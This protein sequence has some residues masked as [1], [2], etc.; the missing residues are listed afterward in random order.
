MLHASL[1]PL[2]NDRVR[3]R[4]LRAEDATAYA[5]GA[6]DPT[7]RRYAHLP[8]PHY[9]PATARAMIEGAARD[10]LE[11]GDLAVL[12]I[13][14]PAD[15][16]F[17]GSLV[18]FDVTEDSAEAGFWL[19]PDA[20]GAGRSAAALDL[21]I[22][23]VRRSGLSGLTAR[24]VTDNTASQRVLEGA[25]FVETGR[26]ASTAPSGQRIEAVHYERWLPR[27]TPALP[28]T[29]ERLAL[30]LHRAGDEDWLRR[31]YE[32]PEVVHYLLDPPWTPQLAER[33]LSER[34]ARTGLES[35]A[36]ALALVVEHESSP[37]GDI[38]LWLTDAAHGI[39]E[40][41]WVLD[42]DHGGR[43][44]ALEA[45]RRVLDLSID[46]C[47]VHRVTAQMDARNGASARLAER[48]GMRHEAHLRQ[49]WWSKGEWTD[50]LVYGLLADDVHPRR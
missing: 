10:G 46:H 19:R 41:G 8:E 38:A 1:L 35:D 3:L 14:D 50:T 17:L 25:G 23:L 21:A 4:P 42:P 5:E 16:S 20:R 45:V 22:D 32:R 34:L 43:G 48:A 47:G 33:R 12:A 18:I 49:D 7:V 13:A 37:I 9:T 31:I 15:D 26:Q 11:R 27:P 24:T 6:E 36:G 40:I 30:R 29:T 28:L 44:Y 2:A 39:A